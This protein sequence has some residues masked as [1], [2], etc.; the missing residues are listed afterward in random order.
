MHEHTLEQSR[1]SVVAPAIK[2]TQAITGALL[3]TAFATNS[4]WMVFGIGTIN[5]AVSVARRLHLWPRLY[6][7]PVPLDLKP[8][9]ATTDAL[10]P[11][12][13]AQGVSG[14]VVLLGGLDLALGLG[15]LG[16]TLVLLVAA[17]TCVNLA[18][19][20]RMG[21]FTYRGL[22]STRALAGGR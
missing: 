3:A 9:S 8:A 19:G 5:L 16:W 7:V 4:V 21:C 6:R 18:T 2:S 17:V 11:R 15:W 1:Q 20:I 10:A 14:A 12:G 22:V 13:F